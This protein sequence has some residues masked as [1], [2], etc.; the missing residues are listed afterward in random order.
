MEREANKA[1]SFAEAEQWDRQQQWAMTPD[2]RH[3]IAKELRDRFY[4]A[5]APDVRESERSKWNR[6]GGAAAGQAGGGASEGPR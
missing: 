5:D 4:G 6:T 2:E 3:A 1:H